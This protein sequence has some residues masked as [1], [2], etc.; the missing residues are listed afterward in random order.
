[1]LTRLRK[2]QCQFRDFYKERTT[3]MITKRTNESKKKKSKWLNDFI[4]RNQN[5]LISVASAHRFY[6]LSDQSQIQECSRMSFSHQFRSFPF[7][8]RQRT[9]GVKNE[10]EFLRFIALHSICYF[11]TNRHPCPLPS[12]CRIQQFPALSGRCGTHL[13]LNEPKG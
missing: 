2:I 4:D 13:N 12:R 8:N 1:M 9:E 7:E 6:S 5:T 3:K 11:P 10:A